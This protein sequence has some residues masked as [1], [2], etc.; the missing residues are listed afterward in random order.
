MGERFQEE[1]KKLAPEE[2]EAYEKKRKEQYDAWEVEVK[3]FMAQ[4]TWKEYMKEAKKFKVPVK[5]F[6]FEK[7]K[8]I[9]TLGGGAAKKPVTK[10]PAAAY[11]LFAQ[12]KKTE[13]VDNEKLEAMWSALD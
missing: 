8:T 10:K 1:F 5:T 3:A 13:E 11:K 6:L 12:E 4:D 2:Q 7:K 9:K